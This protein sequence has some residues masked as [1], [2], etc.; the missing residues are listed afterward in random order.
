MTFIRSM[1][2]KMAQTKQAGRGAALGRKLTVA[3]AAV[4][5]V[6]GGLWL[7]LPG[8]IAQQLQAQATEALGRAVTVRSVEVAPW[9]LALTVNGLEV[10]GAAGARASVVGG[11]RLHQR[12]IEQLVALGACALMPWSWISRWCACAKMRKVSGTLQMF[13]P[14]CS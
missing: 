14:S 3:A 12:F 4:L 2:N 11:A 7:A 10:A 9:S 6:W 5:V 8:V 13:W 1:D